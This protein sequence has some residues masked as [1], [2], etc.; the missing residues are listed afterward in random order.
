MKVGVRDAMTKNLSAESV[1]TRAVSMPFASPAYTVP[2]DRFLDR[3]SLTISYRSDLDPIASLVP[4]PLTVSDPVVSITF[5]YMRAPKLG[6]YYEVAQSISA[7]L[8]G[9]PVSF[10]PAMFAGS[11]AAILQGREVWGLP[12]KFAE[13]MLRVSYDTVVGTLKYSDSL[14]AQAT[15]GYGYEQMGHEEALKA[16]A[17]PGAVLKIIPHV[18]GSPRVL[19]LVRFDYGDVQVKEAYQGP[20]TLQLFEHA[21]APLATLPVREIISA[22]HTVADV[23]LLRGEVVHDYLV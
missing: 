22:H 6:N 14:V 16:A 8:D 19:E 17:T 7:D 21:L 23:T 1:R 12:K 10:R 18:D 5:L 2:P 20:A 11:V 9:E 15:M 3:S 4:E 13:P